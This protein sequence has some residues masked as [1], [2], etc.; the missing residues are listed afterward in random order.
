MKQYTLV[1]AVAAAIVGISAVA[2]AV[3]ANEMAEKA[4]EKATEQV[5][6]EQQKV[7]QQKAEQEKAEMAAVESLTEISAEDLQV[8]IDTN[9]EL[10]LIDARRAS[11]YAQGHIPGAVAVTPGE[12]TPERLAALA[13]DK[14]APMVFYCGNHQCPASG[15]AAYKAAQLGYKRLYKYTEGIEDWRA[16]GLPVV[17]E[18]NAAKKA[19]EAEA[20]VAKAEKTAAE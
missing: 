2:G 15:K 10:V 8:L 19:E 17:T 1:A 16:K 5:Q 4:A 7:E 11:E 13:P 3:R 18:K 9:P 14:E 20:K 12:A 6:S